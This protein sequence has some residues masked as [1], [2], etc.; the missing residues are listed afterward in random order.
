MKKLTVAFL[1]FLIACTIFAGGRS[2]GP[3][4]EKIVFGYVA[5]QLIDVWNSYTMKGF[6]YAAAKKNVEVVG[7]DPE[8]NQEKSLAAVE[9]PVSYT[10]L[11]A[12]ET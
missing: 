7:I 1:L 11:R 8:G 9:D 3:A 4:E 5:Y 12:H 2:G 10:H 6:E